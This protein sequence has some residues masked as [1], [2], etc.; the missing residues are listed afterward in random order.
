MSDSLLQK[1]HNKAQKSSSIL[2]T[3]AFVV[4]IAYMRVCHH[5]RYDAIMTMNQNI[6][7][8]IFREQYQQLINKITTQ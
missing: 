8:F 4:E 7:S 5:Y 3:I 2:L 6:I 1:G